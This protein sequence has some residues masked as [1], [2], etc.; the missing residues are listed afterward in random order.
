MNKI[1]RKSTF[2]FFSPTTYKNQ[3]NLIK[4]FKNAWLM[5]TTYFICILE[6]IVSV[7]FAKF[8]NKVKK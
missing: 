5:R 3:K 2:T 6:F 7:P 8:H 4:N 1:F